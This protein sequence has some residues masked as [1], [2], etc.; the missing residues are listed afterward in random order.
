MQKITTF[1]TFQE[2][3]ADAVKFYVSIFKDSRILNFNV[4]EQNEG[5]L[6]KGALLMASFIL[7]GQEFMAMDGGEHF[8]FAQGTS[9]FIKCD[10][11]NEVDQLWA[12]L[13]DGGEEQ[14]CG[15]LVDKY[16]VSWQVVP[17]ILSTYMSDSDPSKVGRVAQ[18]MFKMKKLDIAKLTAAYKG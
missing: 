18:A 2:H 11:Q 16:G 13:S 4:N 8:N 6:P 3:G 15:W 14:P 9:L 5:P 7:D 17:T 12:K 1:L 10:T